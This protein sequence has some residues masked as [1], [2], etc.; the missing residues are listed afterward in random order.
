MVISVYQPGIHLERLR[1]VTKNLMRTCS[2]AEISNFLMRI[3]AIRNCSVCNIVL[4]Y[5]AGT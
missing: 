2:L 1:K 4:A 3:I 5:C